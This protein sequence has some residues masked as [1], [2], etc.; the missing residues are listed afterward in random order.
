MDVIGEPQYY[1]ILLSLFAISTDNQ[2]M[3][4]PLR[5]A[6]ENQLKIVP[7]IVPIFQ[8]TEL[9]RKPSTQL[10]IANNISKK[11]EPFR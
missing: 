3:P 9:P 11:I 8:K 5:N 4:L 6:R 2:Y 1:S 10:A 7:V